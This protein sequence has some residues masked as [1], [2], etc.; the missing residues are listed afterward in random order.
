MYGKGDASLY[1]HAPRWG[2]EQKSWA[3]WH[4]QV[5]QP[6]PD[7]RRAVLEPFAKTL[8]RLRKFSR[9]RG[10]QEMPGGKYEVVHCT[11]KALVDT[12]VK[13]IRTSTVHRLQR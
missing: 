7:K 10:C 11:G 12:G 13:V 5:V 4:S 8:D 2:V 1:L 9:R 3:L 6:T